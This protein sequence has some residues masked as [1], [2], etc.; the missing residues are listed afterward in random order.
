MLMCNRV[1]LCAV[2]LTIGSLVIGAP[3]VAAENPP[4]YS[5]ATEA[6]RQGVKAF[7]AGD[8]AIAVPAL[9][10]AAKRGVLGA[11]VRLAR[12]YASGRQVPKDDAKAFSYFE[13][14]ADQ[15]AD[16][17]PSSPVAAYVAEAFV[18]L[19]QYYL[20]G[21]PSMPLPANPSI[22]ADLFRHAASYFGSAEAQY[23]LARLYL[24][25]NGVEKNVR[26]AVNWLAIAVKEQHPAAQAKL[27]EIL[28]RG[29]EVQKRR[30][31][32]LA[33]IVLAY[34]N[35]Q[36]GGKDLTWIAKLYREALALSDNS[37]RKEAEALL[38]ELGSVKTITI[39]PA[40]PAE[41]VAIPA[42]DETLEPAAPVPDATL[43]AGAAPAPIGLSVG[44]SSGA[45][46]GGQ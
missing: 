1:V 3:A 34:E 26:L 19:G 27:G 44:F 17:N 16:I 5:S 6:Y 12:A 39:M 30:A 7:K 42:A 18:A 9:E 43:G 36:D 29:R 15:R 38:P 41:V 8:A 23:Q 2:V 37:I 32:G 11:Q 13:Q 40:K 35:A 4:P 24:D 33:L 22:A 28:W 25:G 31:R 46:P 10:Y 20:D 21:I 14:I 45:G